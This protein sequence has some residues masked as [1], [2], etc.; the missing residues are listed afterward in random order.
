MKK[1]TALSLSLL[2]ATVALA[3]ESHFTKYDADGDQ[4]V[5]YIEFAQKKVSEFQAL[6]RD[7][8]K[9]LTSAEFEKSEPAAEWDLFALPEFAKMDV[10]GDANVAF[11]EYGSAVKKVFDTLDAIESGTPDGQVV[12]GEYLAAVSQKKAAASAAAAATAAQKGSAG[13]KK[14]STTQPKK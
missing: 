6:D 1:L 10:D 4:A 7:R 14:G 13:L 3:D 9:T 11:K 12:K 8:S 2:F 5:R